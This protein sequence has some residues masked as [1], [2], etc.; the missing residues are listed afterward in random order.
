MADVGGKLIGI[1]A[2]NLADMLR[3][4][5]AAGRPADAG[6]ASA[7]AAGSAGATAAGTGPQAAAGSAGPAEGGAGTPAGD[8]LALPVEELH[9][10]LRSHNSLRREGI[11]TVGELASRTE[12]QLLAIDQIGPASV[13]EIRQKLA[14]R[15][16]SLGATADGTPAGR[17]AA[18]GTA[19]SAGG[20]S[21]ASK[22]AANGDFGQPA[23][24][25]SPR[26]AAARPPDEDAIDLLS[27]AGLP[28][29][30]R[31]LPVLAGLVVATAIVLR[32]RF[33]RR[34]AA[35]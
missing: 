33:R 11:H 10:A 4:D 31:A 1:F 23:A 32:L 27:V 19:S 21:A 2:A 30:K 8:D 16:L 35:R 13:E 12:Q 24:V 20:R 28:V 5:N 9:L 22:V 26:P 3:A 29:L 18:G 6:S 25:P 7:A 15:G 34:R 14:E 17:T